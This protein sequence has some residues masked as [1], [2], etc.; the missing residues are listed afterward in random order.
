VDSHERDIDDRDQIERAFRRLTL[1]QR[2]V[3]VL[4]HH[5]GLSLAE[6]AAVLGIPLGTMKSR[7][8]RA[9]DALRAAVEADERPPLIAERGTA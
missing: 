5:L 3:L 2:T 9:T 7:L 4:N 8:N 1:E 6:S